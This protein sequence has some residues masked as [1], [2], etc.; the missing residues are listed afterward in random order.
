MEILMGLLGAS[1]ALAA[2]LF[3]YIGVAAVVLRLVD[4][5]RPEMSG[6]KQGPNIPVPT[7]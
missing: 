1:L 4:R 7:P 6:P 5:L 3:L 2:V